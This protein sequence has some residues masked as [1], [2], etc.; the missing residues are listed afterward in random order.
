MGASLA[1]LSGGDPRPGIIPS[2][3]SVVRTA[4]LSI[5]DAGLHLFDHSYSQ[6]IAII[7]PIKSVNATTS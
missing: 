7:M 6:L 4:S 3:P 2:T 5:K 1:F